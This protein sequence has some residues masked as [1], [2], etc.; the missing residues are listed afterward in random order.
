MAR[1]ATTTMARPMATIKPVAI[2]PVTTETMAA[3]NPVTTTE[4]KATIRTSKYNEMSPM[5]KIAEELVN[6]KE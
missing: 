6:D 2:N 3:S 5:R 4:T 1:P